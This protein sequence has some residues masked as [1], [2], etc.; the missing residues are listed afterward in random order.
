MVARLGLSS[1]TVSVERNR[2]GHFS[3]L[4]AGGRVLPEEALRYSARFGYGLAAEWVDFSLLDARGA[5][6]WG[7]TRIDA[8]LAGNAWVDVNAPLEPGT[9]TLLAEGRSASW[10]G[11][12]SG[13]THPQTRTFTVAANAPAPPQ[14]P[15]NGFQLPEVGNLFGNPWTIILILGALLALGILI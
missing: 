14:S 5:T 11:R 6:V 1:H 15:G 7:P 3:I 9:Y 4:S 8:N 13:K 10:A 2:E 12:W